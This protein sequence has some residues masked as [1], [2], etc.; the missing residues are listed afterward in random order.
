MTYGRVG[1]GSDVLAG[2]VAL[3]ALSTFSGTRAP[4]GIEPPEITSSLA[5]ENAKAGTSAWQGAILHAPAIEAYASEIS[6]RPGKTVRFH[7]STDPAAPYE[8]RVY[9]LGWYGGL[10]G[11]LQAVLANRGEPRPGTADAQGAGWPV[12]DTLTVPEGWISGYYL[13]RFVLVGGPYAGRSASTVVVVRAHSGRRA[14]ILVQV[15]VN[16]WQAYNSWGG[17]SLYDFNSEGGRAARVSFER[18]YR[19]GA[20]RAFDWELPLV[21]FLE[22]EGHD[23]SYQTDVDTHREPASL[24]G[25][26]LVIVAGHS[27]YWTSR[28]RDAFEAARDQGTN[29]AF[30]GAN[31]G[32]WQVR[33]EDGGRTLVGYKSSDDP[34]AD[35]ALRTVQFRDLT[36]PR[37]ECP[38][39]GVQ[40]EKGLLPAGEPPR[41]YTVAAPDDPWFAGT[42][43]T[44]STVLPGLVGPEWDAQSC[45]LP[46]LTVLFHYE[47][48]PSDADAVRY[49]APSGARVFSAGSL[50]LSSL[51][52]DHPADG[53]GPPSFA[54][55][56]LQR[57]MRNA[58]D[59]LA[60][61]ARPRAL[62]VRVTGS[63]DVAVRVEGPPDP[64]V[65][66][67]A[68]FRDGVLVCSDAAPACVDRDAPGHRR[69]TYSAA[70]VDAWGTS[71]PL[72]AT[73]VR[74]PNR[75]PSVALDGP[76]SLPAGARA[77][78][79]AA[80][81]DRDGDALTLSWRID[82]R[83]VAR[84]GSRLPVRF[85]RPGRHVIE[86]EARDRYG[87]RSL[88]RVTVLVGG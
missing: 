55:A 81:T 36:P 43:F 49:T 45:P 67:A 58:L 2:R 47:G 48:R 31:I 74:V 26:R 85:R 6:V 38:L 32:F 62:E 61:P 29:L 7:V 59:D 54:A 3:A 86:L 75:S 71:L 64:R 25:H 12:T 63:G 23:I 33:Y 15:P 72:A 80:A 84:R 1:A 66:A 9:R 19:L 4:A 73:P 83:P 10:G 18:P 21:R 69:H 46:G 50:L 44:R 68:V 20:A 34:V 56:G 14:R 5:A 8:I 24:L 39:L 42:G 52:D 51:L 87:G 28:M 22:S 78:Y 11:R 53:A 41:P 37:S 79:A 13:A 60:R 65:R 76:R 40:W 27:E 17:K 57:F 70:S 35:P 77:V 82:G 30:M 88:A 16:T